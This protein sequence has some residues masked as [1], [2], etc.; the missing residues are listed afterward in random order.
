MNEDFKEITINLIS[1]GGALLITGLLFILVAWL[2]KPDCG[3]GGAGASGVGAA[4][5]G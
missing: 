1:W 5:D 4:I 2:A 3:C